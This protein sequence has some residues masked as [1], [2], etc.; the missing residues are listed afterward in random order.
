MFSICSV[1]YG[2]Q[3][4]R[5]GRRRREAWPQ[6]RAALV[7]LRWPD[8]F[9]CPCCGSGALR[10]GGSSLSIA[11]SRH[12]PRRARSSTTKLPLL[13]RSHPPGRDGE[14]RH[15][16]GLGRRLGVEPT[17][18]RSTR[19]AVMARREGET[20]LTGRVEMTPIS[21]APAAS[22]A[23]ARRSRRPSWRRSRPVPRGARQ[24][25]AYAGQGLQRE[26]AR[27]AKHWLA[28]GA[29]VV[30]DGLGAGAHSTKPP[31]ATRRSAPGRADRRPAWHVQM[32]ERSATSRAH[33]RRLSQARPRPCRTA[34]PASP[35][36]VTNDPAFRS[37][38]RTR[39]CPIARTPVVA[40]R[41]KQ[42][43]IWDSALLGRVPR[44]IE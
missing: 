36:A 3:A 28:P 32:G 5:V 11:R 25:E 19:L 4:S 44:L 16:V 29:A 9:V 34:S 7:R 14:E 18:G 21:A 22:G 39:P 10:A 42:E 13:V 37:A 35:G 15:L 24:A 12:R 8:G 40:F 26:I 30:T 6:C 2:V 20:R 17:V 1:G 41:D 23:A 27:G 38:A 31:A 33:P 43:P